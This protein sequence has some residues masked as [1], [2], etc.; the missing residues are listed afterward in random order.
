M[1]KNR[2]AASEVTLIYMVFGLEENVHEN[3]KR[4]VRRP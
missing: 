2:C 1:K 3:G 4:G